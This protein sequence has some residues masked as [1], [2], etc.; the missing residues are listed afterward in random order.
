[1][2]N[3]LVTVLVGVSALGSLTSCAGEDP[4]ILGTLENRPVPVVGTA[5]VPGQV[6]TPVDVPV[7]VPVVVDPP[8]PY[9]PRE[10]T[11]KLLAYYKTRA[12]KHPSRIEGTKML[13]EL[14]RD[15]NFEVV[16]TETDEHINREGLAQFEMVFFVNTTGDV[17]NDR[18]Q[19]DFEDWLMDGGAFAGTHSA[20]DTEEKWD[21]Y[22]EVT[23]EYFNG[24]GSAGTQDQVRWED[25]QLDHPAV[26][27]LPNP[28]RRSEEWY[29]F[30]GFVKQ[31]NNNNQNGWRVLG[32]IGSNNQPITYI[33]EWGSFRS[34]YTGLGHDEAVFKDDN[35][36]KH[37]LGAIMWGVRRDHLLDQ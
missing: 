14:G 17:F 30:N 1:M 15:N 33:R 27:G 22:K 8:D 34:F 25:D 13:Q 24:H 7:D 11:F 5:P 36:K 9:S 19:N 35:F 10:G 31:L 2:Q 37:I 3:T 20:T 32:R 29:R 4:E 12:F 23:G 18:Q 21:F 6:G 26:R 28:W 16:V